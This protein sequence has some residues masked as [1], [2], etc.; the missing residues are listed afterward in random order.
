MRTAAGQQASKPPTPAHPHSPTSSHRPAP[1]L[2]PP[3]SPRPQAYVDLLRQV[4]LAARRSDGAAT[5][6]LRAD[7]PAVMRAVAKQL[8]HKSA[9]TKV[10]GGEGGAGVAASSVRC[11]KRQ[12]WACFGAPGGGPAGYC[13]WPVPN[14]PSPCRPTCC[15]TRRANSLAVSFSSCVPQVGVFRVLLELV[16]VTPDAVG[17]HAGELLPGIQAALRDPSSAGA[18]SK[19]QALQFLN[20]GACVER[21]GAGQAGTCGKSCGCLVERCVA[22]L[23][24]PCAR[25]GVFSRVHL[26]AG[27]EELRC[28]VLACAAGL[29]PDACKRTML[30]HMHP[31]P[32]PPTPPTPPHLHAHAT[33]AA[34]SANSP[35]TFQ[36]SAAALSK[37][38]FEAVG[39]RYYKASSTTRCFRWCPAGVRGGSAKQQGLLRCV[40]AGEGGVP[41]VHGRTLPRHP[42]CPLDSPQVA[43]EALRVCEQLV[44]VV[45]PDVG[46]PMDA[47]LQASR[48][49]GRVAAGSGVPQGR[50]LWWPPHA[51]ASSPESLAASTAL[52]EVSPWC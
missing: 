47:S 50:W 14:T 10:G 3:P 37:P 22:L 33:A 4:G 1:T 39:E 30:A 35:A 52:I 16:A 38:V 9:K 40:A 34:M 17:G 28:C 11:Q 48:P 8:R 27:S 6:L 20:S 25:G 18:S 49:G 29:P 7:I 2:P 12:P 23:L 43:A 19:I 13:S 45:R 41:R 42:P 46:A 36:P 15:I 24:L 32:P 44:R 31:P 26:E 51:V 5:G 21:R